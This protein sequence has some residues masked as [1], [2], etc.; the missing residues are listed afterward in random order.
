MLSLDHEFSF[1][2]PNWHRDGLCQEYPGVDWFPE[3]GQSGKDA[4][5]VCQR[6]KVQTECLAFALDVRGPLPGI[7]GASSERE[8]RALRH[9][10][11]TGDLVRKYGPN[12]IAGQQEER[13]AEI[14][15]AVARFRYSV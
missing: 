5:S 10:G 6:C 12:A 7:W 4:H 2:F 14:D 8:R 3:R 11:V 13:E 1:Q 9:A 15:L